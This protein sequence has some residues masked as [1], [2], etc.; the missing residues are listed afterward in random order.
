MPFAIP[1]LDPPVQSLELLVTDGDSPY[2]YALDTGNKRI[3]VI[4]KKTGLIKNQILSDGFT[5][6][7]S[8]VLNVKKHEL[9]V[10]NDGKLLRIPLDIK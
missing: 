1:P 7:K 2:L 5:N 8:F 10:I 6:P 9:V 3:V 4:D